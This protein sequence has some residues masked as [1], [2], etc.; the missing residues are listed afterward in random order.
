MAT[1]PNPNHDTVAALAQPHPDLPVV[2]VQRLEVLVDLHRPGRARARV[3]A[4]ARARARATATAT[5]EVRARARARVRVRV[6]V[7]PACR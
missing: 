7:R 2:V 5:A 1:N 3:E 6:R 4:R